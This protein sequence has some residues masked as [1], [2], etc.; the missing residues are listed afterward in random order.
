M[1]ISLRPP[2]ARYLVPL[3]TVFVACVVK[4]LAANLVGLAFPY[5][6]VVAA[7]VASALVAGF[8]AGMIAS[9]LGVAAANFFFVSEGGE[10]FRER[11]AWAAVF[12]AEGA[13]VSWMCARVA[14]AHARA[15]SARLKLSESE[16]RFRLVADSLPTPLWAS[17]ADGQVTFFNKAWLEFTG[18]SFSQEIGYGWTEGVHPEDLR[19]CLET[20]LSSVDA[21]IPF[22]MEYRLRAFD[23][24]YRWI[25]DAGIPRF[26]SDGTLEGYVGYVHDVTERIKARAASDGL[27]ARLE[28][29]AQRAGCGLFSVDSDGVIV[30]VGASACALLGC[31]PEELEGRPWEQVFPAASTQDPQDRRCA[32][33]AGVMAK[34][35]SGACLADVSA[36]DVHLG[37][38]GG[39]DGLEKFTG[40]RLISYVG[41][42]GAGPASLLAISFKRLPDGHAQGLVRKALGSEMFRK[43]GLHLI[44]GGQSSH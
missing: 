31:R 14:R 25:S 20:Y 9:V 11:L 37:D 3:I 10:T 24:A 7:I 2:M 35:R 13:L 15:R 41:E 44:A 17:D 40:E 19:Q 28:F 8:E 33:D 27:V 18:R 39:E 26:R 16:R 42:R 32:S 34:A 30:T 22:K 4:L 5:F 36:E 12:I 21:M 6:L 23:G 43:D 1:K 38:A 29:L